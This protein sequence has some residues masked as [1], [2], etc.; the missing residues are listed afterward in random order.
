MKRKK[1]YLTKLST[2]WRSVVFPQDVYTEVYCLFFHTWP[3]DRTLE[4]MKFDVNIN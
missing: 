3:N 2:E 1:S 4:F